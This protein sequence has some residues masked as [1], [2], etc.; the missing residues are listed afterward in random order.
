[1]LSE[2]TRPR[3]DAHSRW[4]AELDQLDALAHELRGRYRVSAHVVPDQATP[5]VWTCVAGTD[6]ERIEVTPDAGFDLT[7]AR[8]THP[9]MDPEGCARRVAT[10]LYRQARH[11]AKELA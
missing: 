1:M 4:L 5:Y 7:Q 8:S 2:W 10:R 11:A 6:G 3:P 9:I